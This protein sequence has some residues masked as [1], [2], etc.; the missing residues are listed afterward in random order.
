[1]TCNFYFD[2]MHF[3]CCCCLFLFLERIH[4]FTLKWKIERLLK[5]TDV[6]STIRFESKEPKPV[7][8]RAR[9]K[10][11]DRTKQF[12]RMQR[13]ARL[14]HFINIFSSAAELLI[15]H[16]SIVDLNKKIK[17]KERRISNADGRYI[18]SKIF[19]IIGTI[20]SH[21]NHWQCIGISTGLEKQLE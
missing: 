1:M 4:T 5:V 21:C 15:L 13:Y 19:T 16:K 18:E 12:H 9:K 3:F 20:A 6:C 10:I 14:A 2:F 11:E 17:K 8:Y 7:V